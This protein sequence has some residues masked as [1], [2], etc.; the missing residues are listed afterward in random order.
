MPK[1]CQIG[2]LREKASAAGGQDGGAPAL[3]PA[4]AAVKDGAN[5]RHYTLDKP[6]SASGF[7]YGEYQCEVSTEHWEACAVAG[8]STAII[9]LT[10]LT[11]GMTVHVALF[12]GRGLLLNVEGRSHVSASW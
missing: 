8:I 6:A 9:I 3:I 10:L 5:S 11:S 2:H 7:V 12:L 1:G 4:K